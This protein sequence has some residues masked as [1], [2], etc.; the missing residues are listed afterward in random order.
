[1]AIVVS[2][3]FAL[4]QIYQQVFNHLNINLILIK[5]SQN[6]YIPRIVSVQSLYVSK[7][8]VSL[9]LMRYLFEGF[10]ITDFFISCEFYPYANLQYVSSWN[11]QRIIH[12]SQ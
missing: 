12:L 11:V 5:N 6:L 7:V 8:F 3:I 2:Q 1:M 10:F 4:S 9:I